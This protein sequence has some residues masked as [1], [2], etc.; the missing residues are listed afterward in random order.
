MKTKDL[1]RRP[2][3]LKASINGFETMIT[4]KNRMKFCFGC[5]KVG[6]VTSSKIV[7]IQ[8][9]DCAAVNKPGHLA[10]DCPDI[11]QQIHLLP[12]L[13]KV[14]QTSIFGEFPTPEERQGKA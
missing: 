6:L 7:R 10:K 11:I 13:R 9:I 14:L 12:T 5:H 3:P 2:L 1:D 8:L 4:C